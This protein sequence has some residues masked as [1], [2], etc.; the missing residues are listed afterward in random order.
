MAGIREGLTMKKNDQSAEEIAKNDA[1][2][3]RVLE[4]NSLEQYRKCH[5][6]YQVMKNTANSTWL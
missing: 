6:D 1:N 4:P 3:L 5:S 2:P